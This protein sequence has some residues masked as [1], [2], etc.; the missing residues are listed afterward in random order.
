MM[1]KQAVAEYFIALRDTNRHFTDVLEFLNTKG[2]NLEIPYNRQEVM[3]V[4]KMLSCDYG[5][6]PI[7]DIRERLDTLS[8]KEIKELV[9]RL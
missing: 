9:N 6:E 3:S 4:I 2:I 1:K 5:E 7:Q 8:N